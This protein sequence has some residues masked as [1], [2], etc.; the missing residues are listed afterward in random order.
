MPITTKTSLQRLSTGLL[1]GAVFALASVPAVAQAPGGGPGVKTPTGSLPP[2]VAATPFQWSTKLG[3]GAVKVPMPGQFG[4]FAV[5]G[6]NLEAR[7]VPSLTGDPTI[8]AIFY[9]PA[10][11]SP[12]NAERVT[13]QFPLD[14]A[15]IPGSGAL[16]LA[17]HSF[18]VSEKD[19]WVNT[20][21][22]QIC[23]ER[24]WMLVAPYGL[25]DT[26]YGNVESQLAL[27]TVMKTVGKYFSWD[28]DRVYAV[29]FSMGGGAALSYSMR[30]ISSSELKIAGVINHTGT[31]DLIAEYNNAGI[32]MKQMLADDQHFHAP[33]TTEDGAFAYKRVSPS[34]FTGGAVDP[35]LTP[36][37]NL[38]HLPIYTF[39][40]LDDPLSQLVSN[41]TAVSAY[42]QGEGMNVNFVAAHKG[43]VHNWSTLDLDAALNWIQGFTLPANPTSATIFA[44]ELAPYFGTT[45]RAKPALR[46]AFYEFS[47][48]APTNSFQV[49]DTRDLDSLVLRLGP[50]GL[51]P[52]LAIGGSWSSQENS[53]DELVLRGYSVAPSQVLMNGTPSTTWTFDPVLGEVVIPIPAGPTSGVLLITP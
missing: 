47:A 22:A 49:H 48:D 30:H 16:V 1:A 2:I 25:V 26:H 39:V 12:T 21:L 9:P 4:W 17:F 41:N 6:E 15:S 35:D 8:E 31:Q 51:D 45:V 7:A 34:I 24:G 50:L 37:R 33:P 19:I 5:T 46:V 52:S 11:G 3:L 43:G 18:S 28:P 20:Q 38:A 32:P 29:G 44:D 27:D 23:K 42:L 40:N 14:P 13:F 53:G 36:L 10:S